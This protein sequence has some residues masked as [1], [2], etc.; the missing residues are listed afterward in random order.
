LIISKGDEGARFQ[1][2]GYELNDT[3]N[4]TT[5]D[6]QSNL[7]H[8]TRSSSIRGQVRHKSFHV[9]SVCA[10]AYFIKLVMVSLKYAKVQA[11]VT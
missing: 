6:Y 1:W 10:F 7:Y 2:G 11:D 5:N 8:V 3:V 4:E 9:T